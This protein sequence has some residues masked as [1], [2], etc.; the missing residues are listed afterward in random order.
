[1][2]LTR[3]LPLNDPTAS[4]AAHAERQVVAALSADCHAPMAVLAEPVAIDPAS[5]LRN[6]DAHWFRLRVRVLSSDGKTCL[7]A[8]EQVKTKDLRRLVR[9]V[10]KDLSGR[11]ARRLLALS[12]GVPVSASPRPVDAAPAAS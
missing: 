9:Q 5:V 1:M 6:A 11:G 3:C 8:D 10:V 2:T 7:D 12:R 4:T